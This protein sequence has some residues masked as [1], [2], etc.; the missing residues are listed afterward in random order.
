MEITDFLQK[1]FCPAYAPL[2][3][4]SLEQH[5]KNVYRR[6]LT[7]DRPPLVEVFLA[8]I[9]LFSSAELS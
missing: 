9:E 8:I 2:D 6:T 5:K 3:D 7:E 4:G 1:Q